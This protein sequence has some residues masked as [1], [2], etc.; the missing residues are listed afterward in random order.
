MN[1]AGNTVARRTWLISLSV[2]IGLIILI[3]LLK[4]TP[5]SVP[6]RR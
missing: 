5:Y 2:T 6:N 4:K 3:E 1:S